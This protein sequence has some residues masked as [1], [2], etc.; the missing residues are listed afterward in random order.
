MIINKARIECRM[1][2]GLYD[3]VRWAAYRRHLSVN[4]YVCSV[5]Q[6]ATQAD[7]REAAENA[8]AEAAQIKAQA[9]AVE[10]AAAAKQSEA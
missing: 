4:K 7:Y 8:D 3:A 1:D 2:L 9:A 6:L 5:L 10:A